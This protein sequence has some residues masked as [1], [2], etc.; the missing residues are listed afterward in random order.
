MK[1]PIGAALR[2][3]AVACALA[4]SSVLLLRPAHAVPQL[5]DGS[6]D[7]DW[8]VGLWR[9]HLQVLRHQPDGSTTWVI[10][11]GTSTVVPIW[12]CRAEMVELDVTGP[13]GH[14]LEALNLRLYDPQSHQWSL[15]FANADVG[16]MSTPTIGGFR[17]GIGTFYDQ[18]AIGGRAVLVRNIWSNVTKSSAHFAQAISDD[19]GKTWQTNWIA[20]D[21]RVKGTADE[22]DSEARRR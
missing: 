15:N 4:S 3:A 19:G 11:Q 20:D 10:Y 13:D 22:C 7:F 8:E 16:V 1:A 12:D 14:H 9:T 5:P 2:A 17:D 18:E 6:H 21:T